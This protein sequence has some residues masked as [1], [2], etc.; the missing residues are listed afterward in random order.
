MSG[1]ETWTVLDLLRWTTAHFGRQGIDTARLDAECLL[2]HALETDR[3]RLYLE[4]DKPVEES[5]RARFRELV[6]RRGAE[7]IPVAHLT[8]RKEF[9]SL[10]LRVTRD[11]L[12]PRPDTET[13]VQAALAVLPAGE[14]AARM[15]DVGTGSGAIALALLSER[16]GLR[17]VATDVSAAAL[18][19]AEQNAEALG[20]RGRL[21]LR[22]G[23]LFAPV[24]GERFDLIVANPPYLAAGEAASLAP[25]LAHEPEAALFAG[26]AGT[27]LIEALV[28]GAPPHLAP[29]GRL[30]VELA[31]AQAP[32]VAGW[33]RAAG[34]GNIAVH[35]DL[36]RRPRVVS[37]RLAGTGG[38]A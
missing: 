26:P 5:E 16:P 27:E 23:P 9:W 6:R 37:G 12:T 38:N 24:A 15:L 33:M 2:A 31:P 10:P 11:V 13:L 1:A 20:L 36:G 22:A 8:G 34:F 29:G 30:M 19:V 14:A 28:A 4:F 21:E 25:E 7:R 35:D 18:A 3:L 17:A 32:A